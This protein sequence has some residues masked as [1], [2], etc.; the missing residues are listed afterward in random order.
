MNYLHAREFLH[1]DLKSKN[2]LIENSYKAK[3]CD[4]GFARENKNNQ[5]LLTVKV[6]TDEWM[7]PEV[8]LGEPYDFKA[9]VFSF[10]NILYELFTREKPFPRQPNNYYCYVE[11]EFVSKILEKT[12][13]NPPSLFLV[14]LTT[15]CIQKDPKLRPMF[16]EILTKLKEIKKYYE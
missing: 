14:Q 15:E 5:S 11:T 6:G 8:I 1:R 2:I 3:L 13:N 4:F 9:D 7:A 10:G 16:S 12:K